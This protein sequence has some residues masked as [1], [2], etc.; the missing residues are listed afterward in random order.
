M[1]KAKYRILLGDIRWPLS[2][3][4]HAC[5]S[6]LKCI[7]LF[8]FAGIRK[9]HFAS[10][11]F[12]YALLQF[13]FSNLSLEITVHL[14]QPVYI[15]SRS[16]SRKKFSPFQI[17][18]EQWNNFDKIPAIFIIFAGVRKNGRIAIVMLIH[19]QA[20]SLQTCPSSV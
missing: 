12:N 13:P 9:V 10:S 14:L 7:P 3:C 18:P 6:L 1:A 2:L 20:Q 15:L 16:L 17:F 4:S 8:V 5:A 19:K 11:L